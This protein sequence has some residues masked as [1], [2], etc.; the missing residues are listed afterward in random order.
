MTCL[1]ASSDATAGKLM[2]LLI[3]TSTSLP[4]PPCASSGYDS[5]RWMNQPAIATTRIT[6]PITTARATRNE[7]FDIGGTR[8]LA[9]ALGVEPGLENERSGLLIDHLLALLP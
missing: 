3:S 7:R 6:E 4:A 9:G 1:D 2:P 8:L 5:A